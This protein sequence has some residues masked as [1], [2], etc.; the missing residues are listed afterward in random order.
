MDTGSADKF[1]QWK[2]K[3]DAEVYKLVFLSC[4]DLP[5]VDYY[6]MYVENTDPKEAAEYA[7][8]Y[9]KSN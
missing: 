1:E 3:V 9:A 2:A 6:S 5:D 4:D 8:E 7:I